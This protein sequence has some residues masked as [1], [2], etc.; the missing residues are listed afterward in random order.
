M[1]RQTE[2]TRQLREATRRASVVAR[3]GA[4]TPQA[5]DAE[6]V[7]GGLIVAGDWAPYGRVGITTLGTPFRVR[8]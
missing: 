5:Q 1:A 7:R 3:S 4:A 2:T 6:P 8:G